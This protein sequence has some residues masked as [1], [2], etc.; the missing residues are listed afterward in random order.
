MRV[1]MFKKLQTEIHNNA[2]T[3]GFWEGEA[4]NIPT[5]LML[6]VS[7]I[8][9][10]MEAHRKNN[11]A[12]GNGHIQG[13]LGWVNEKDFIEH[14]E[15]T[16]KDTFQDELADAMIRI[17]DLAEKMDIDLESHIKAKMRYNKSRPFM[18]NVKY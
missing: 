1:N 7:E 14:F 18:H 11:F 9:E 6:I 3:K 8:S 5:K 15:R 12:L 16:E 17:L 4:A 13:V 10:A 2:V